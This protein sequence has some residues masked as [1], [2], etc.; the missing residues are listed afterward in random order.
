MSRGRSK[1]LPAPAGVI[2][3]KRGENAVVAVNIGPESVRIDVG[4]TV[5]IGTDRGRDA[6]VVHGQLLLRS[7][8]AVVLKE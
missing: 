3:L 4:G 2:L 8:E 7:N 5:A 6:E 1:L